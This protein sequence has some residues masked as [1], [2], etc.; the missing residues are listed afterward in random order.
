VKSL[1]PKLKNSAVCATM[2]LDLPEA[3]VKAA[4]AS[5]LLESAPIGD[6]LAA[7]LRRRKAAADLGKVL[8][9]IRAQPAEPMTMEEIQ[10]E[11]DAVRAERRAREAR[12]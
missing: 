8:D 2:R 3:L 4:Q 11:V 9:T 6:L 10:A 12:R 1:V 5:G 7:E